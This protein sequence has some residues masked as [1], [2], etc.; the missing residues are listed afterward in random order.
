[1]DAHEFATPAF[2]VGHRLVGVGHGAEHLDQV[3]IFNTTIF[4]EGH[5]EMVGGK[6]PGVRCRLSGVRTGGRGQ[7]QES[8]SG[9]RSQGSGSKDGVRGIGLRI[10]VDI[11]R[12][13]V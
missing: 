8:G 9:V 3:A 11:S 10:V 12:S 5:K 2:G 7:G 13:R 4:V 6:V 1:M